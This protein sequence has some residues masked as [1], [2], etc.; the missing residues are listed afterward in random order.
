M[1]AVLP[2]QPHAPLTK[3]RI[4]RK[5]KPLTKGM[6]ESSPSCPVG[7]GRCYSPP[8]T[9]SLPKVG[10]ES[11]KVSQLEINFQS[12]SQKKQAMEFANR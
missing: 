10:T 2:A 4:G 3:G 5:T 7:E 11:E 12:Q 1:G 8:I 9:A 6:S